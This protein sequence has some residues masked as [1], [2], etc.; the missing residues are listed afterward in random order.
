VVQCP[1]AHMHNSD[2]DSRADPKVRY[3]VLGICTDFVIC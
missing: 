1:Q 2:R 3:T